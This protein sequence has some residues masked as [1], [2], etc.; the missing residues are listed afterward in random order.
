MF[1]IN[2]GVGFQITFENGWQISVQF[3]PAHHC[4]NEDIEGFMK[5]TMAGSYPESQE[6]IDAEIAI[7]DDKQ[8][9][10][11]KGAVRGWIRPQVV[12]Q[13]ITHLLKSKPNPESLEL[14]LA[15]K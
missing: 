7:F 12:G 1:R 11:L 4:A 3:G 6:S 14:I 2:R 13:L 5:Q 9:F 15:G 8:E 10:V